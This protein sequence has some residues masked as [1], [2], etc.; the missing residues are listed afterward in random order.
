MLTPNEFERLGFEIRRDGPAALVILRH[1]AIAGHV[2][3]SRR[4]RTLWRSVTVSGQLRH[5]RSVSAGVEHIVSSY[6]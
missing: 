6:Q 5:V 2:E 1:G 3:R 4:D